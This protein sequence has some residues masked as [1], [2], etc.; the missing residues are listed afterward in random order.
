MGVG[1]LVV[2]LPGSPLISILFLTQALNAVLLLPLLGFIAF[3][4]RDPE[5][6]GEHAAGAW[7][8]GIAV[9]LTGLIAAAT[10]ALALLSIP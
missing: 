10:L 7:G 4:I 1:A 9:A 5:L 2:L 6:L 8:T 3:L